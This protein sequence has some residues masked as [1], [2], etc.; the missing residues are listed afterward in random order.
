MPEVTDPALIAQLDAAEK[1]SSGKEVTDPDLIAKLDAA[2]K[3]PAS[4]NTFQELSDPN[5]WGRALALA[6]RA[7]LE[8]PAQLASLPA[9]AATEVI[10]FAK[11]PYKPAMNPLTKEF[12]HEPNRP[13]DLK[14]AGNTIHEAYTAA[15]FPEPRNM[16]EKVAYG[17]ESVLAGAKVPAGPRAI[18]AAAEAAAGRAPNTLESI[19]KGLSK[20]SEETLK[21]NA[22]RRVQ[23]KQAKDAK[24]AT[25]AIEKALANQ[26]KD[27]AT[28][29]TKV[30]EAQEQGVPLTLADSVPNTGEV[31]AQHPRGGASK[32]MEESRLGSL[33][34]EKRRVPGEVR[35]ATG[36]EDDYGLFTQGLANTRSA[37][38]RANYEAVR[39]D[40]TPVT[41]PQIWKILENPL[42]A[43]LYQEARNQHMEERSLSTLAGNPSPELADIYA[44]KPRTG[45]PETG[46]REFLPNPA[47]PS[48]VEWVRTGTA[49]DVKSLDYLIRNIDEKITELYKSGVTGG[50][51]KNLKTVRNMLKGRLETVSPAYQRASNTYALDSEIMDA[52]ELGNKG[53]RKSVV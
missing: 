2:E 41:D 43:K 30:K 19:G 7:V 25:A 39:Q 10:N 15:G 50:T 52:R 40:A 5:N 24:K 28:E 32:I 22:A 26:K 34:D 53:D 27:I 9:D 35:A 16:G 33:K 8:A 1:A 23:A 20:P 46:G 44:P 13:G 48:G 47:N 11:N 36:T 14:T 3:Q 38:A 51:A 17:V 45:L 6:G 37:S 4:Q 49:P 42:V 29:S 18:P 31:L 12:W 21:T